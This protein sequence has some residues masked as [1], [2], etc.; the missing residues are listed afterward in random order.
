[1]R[2]VIMILTD[3]TIPLP[4]IEPNLVWVALI[5]QMTMS[6]GSTGMEVKAEI[7]L[8]KLNRNEVREDIK[9]L[10]KEFEI[11]SALGLHLEAPKP[12]VMIWADEP[13]VRV[14]FVSTRTT[15]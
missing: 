7:V 2:Q 10:A 11:E 6:M 5:K 3:D 15:P 9:V 8:H 13:P 4:P 12:A 14:P 1:M